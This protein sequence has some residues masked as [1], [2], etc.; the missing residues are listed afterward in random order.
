MLEAVLQPAPEAGR[1]LT[2]FQRMKSF[3]AVAVTYWVAGRALTWLTTF[4]RREGVAIWALVA[5]SFAYI[6]LST[7]FVYF[8]YARRCLSGRGRARAVGAGAAPSVASKVD[9][10]LGAAT[11]GVRLPVDAGA[12]SAG[13]KNGKRSG[14]GGSRRE[15]EQRGSK[16]EEEMTRL[17]QGGGDDPEPHAKE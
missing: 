5:G 13:E 16:G 9:P 4:A 12:E 2:L 10:A 11:D 14:A 17:L 1:P 7:I 6:A 15:R 3:G 8:V